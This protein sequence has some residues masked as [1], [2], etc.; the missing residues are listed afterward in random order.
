MLVCLLG[1][2]LA[3][4]ASDSLRA[5]Y[6]AHQLSQ[7]NPNLWLRLVPLPDTRLAELDGARIER[8]GISMQTPWTAMEKE[9]DFTGV[10][11]L[12][13]AQ[14][15]LL[16]FDPSGELELD[17]SIRTRGITRHYY[18]RLLDRKTYKTDFDLMAAEMQATPA[19]VKWW[20]TRG[21]HV[22]N[23]ALLV[24]KE[25]EVSNRPTMIYSVHF[26]GLR[27]FQFGDPAVA[28][29]VVKLTLFDQKDRRYDFSVAGRDR[30]HPTLSQAQI[31]A[32]VNSIRPLP[33]KTG[34]T[35][36]N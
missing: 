13:F 33:V 9:R 34:S 3:L 11:S 1:I 24:F 29:F 16:I 17:K 8:L 26:G 28:P 36:P 31:N 21:S 32:F 25:T 18:A 6:F 7:D 27:G 35:V 19:Q 30:Q 12:D 23:M 22:R 5:L 15:R 14:A 10:M 20:A 2:W 4:Y